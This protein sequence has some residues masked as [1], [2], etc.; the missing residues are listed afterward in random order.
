M[1]I[2]ILLLASLFAFTNIS[3]SIFQTFANIARLKFK[4]GVVDNFQ[5]NGISISNKTR[6]EDFSAQEIL[7]ISSAVA[8]GTLPVSFTLN[9]EALNPNDGT[10]GY[11][12]TNA[13]LKSFPWRLLMNDKETISGNIGS[14]VTVP[15]TG[16]TTIIPFQMN[17]DLV[18]FFKDEGYNSLINLALTLGGRNGSATNLKMFAKPTVTST[19]GDITYPRE[20]EIV[21]HEFRN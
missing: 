5:L 13:T 17:L 1:K 3:C 6:I 7:Q 16:E 15:G 9:V 18:R 12:R 21:N 19:I 10:G 14:P 20:L 11:P 4:L 2:K 8:R